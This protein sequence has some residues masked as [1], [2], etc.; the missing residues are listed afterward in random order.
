MDRN[1]HPLDRTLRRR[2]TV[3]VV[4]R[5]ICGH[6]ERWPLPLLAHPGRCTCPH[7]GGQLRESAETVT[8][9]VAFGAAS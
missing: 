4:L 1:A 7:C 5:C 2:R 8:P 3:L 6:S 9:D